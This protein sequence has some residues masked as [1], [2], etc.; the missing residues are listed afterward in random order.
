VG[1]AASMTRRVDGSVA[2]FVAVVEV[3]VTA[4]DAR[5]VLVVAGA[6]AVDV[7][8]V[9]VL[10]ADIDVVVGAIVVIGIGVDRARARGSAQAQGKKERLGSEEVLDQHEVTNSN[11]RATPADSE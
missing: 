6:R 5:V 2:V 1:G 9:A 8:L 4:G 7:A 10:V 3:G 11:G